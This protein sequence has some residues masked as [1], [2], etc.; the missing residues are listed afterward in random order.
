MRRKKPPNSKLFLLTTANHCTS[1]LTLGYG[2]TA[3][4]RSRTSSWLR[5]LRVSSHSVKGRT[6]VGMKAEEEEEEE[7]LL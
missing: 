5:T 7:D 2:G 6:G 3:L 4:R 1:W